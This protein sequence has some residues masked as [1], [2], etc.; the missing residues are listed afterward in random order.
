MN[1][2]SQRTIF[3][4]ENPRAETIKGYILAVAIGL[5]FFVIFNV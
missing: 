1:R 4:N 5:F 3:L 2:Y